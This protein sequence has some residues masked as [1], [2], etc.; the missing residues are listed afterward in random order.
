MVDF[1]TRFGKAVNRRL[2]REAIIWLTTVDRRNRPQPRPVWFDWDGKSILI[3]SQPGAAKVRHLADNRNVALNLNSD[4][5][6]EAV[7]V[8]LGEAKTLKRSVGAA[9]LAAY[10]KKYREGIETLGM[11]PAE[12]WASYSTAIQVKPTALRGF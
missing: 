4:A 5:Q 3:F 12:F 1:N 6:G 10:L 7:T 8:L 9:R 2:R 11:T